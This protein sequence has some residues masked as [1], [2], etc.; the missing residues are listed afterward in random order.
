MTKKII[1]IL[2]SIVFCSFSYA[3]EKDDYDNF[4]SDGKSYEKFNG[5]A[6]D[7][8]RDWN[9]VLA[10]LTGQGV[11]VNSVDWTTIDEKCKVEKN[12]APEFEFFKCKYKNAVQYNEYNNDK[13]YCNSVSEQSYYKYLKKLKLQNES[14]AL[15][16]S[17]EKTFKDSS[18][19][20]CMRK[21]GWQ[22]PE[23]WTRRNSRLNNRR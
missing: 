6:D 9:N 5:S 3:E 2:L 13:K 1:I 22:N 18:V 11:D 21:M 17:D 15:S 16:P 8:Y 20:V 7:V 12:G 10:K 14:K 23:S 4:N 19:S